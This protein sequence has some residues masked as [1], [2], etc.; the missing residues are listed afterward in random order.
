[1][2]APMKMTDYVNPLLMIG[3]AVSVAIMVNSFFAGV[4]TACIIA[5]WLINKS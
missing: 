4:A 1:M 5:L 2:K 3:A